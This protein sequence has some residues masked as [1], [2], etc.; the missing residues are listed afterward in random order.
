MKYFI[1]YEDWESQ[2]Y[3]FFDSKEELIKFC[4][5]RFRMNDGF[6]ILEIIQGIAQ[7]WKPYQRIQSIEI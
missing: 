3:S 5:E 7:T 4:E 2:S 6:K 1:I